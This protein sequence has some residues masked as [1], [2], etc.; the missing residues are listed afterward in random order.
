M[1]LVE[2]TKYLQKQ[3]DLLVTEEALPGDVPTV[4]AWHTG[5]TMPDPIETIEYITHFASKNPE[6]MTTLIRKLKGKEGGMEGL[7][8]QLLEHPESIN[9]LVK[10]LD[11]EKG[12]SHAGGIARAMAERFRTYMDDFHAVNESDE[13]SSML[14]PPV[15]YGD[16]DMPSDEEGGDEEEL[17]PNDEKNYDFDDD[18]DEDE[19]DTDKD[20]EHGEMPKHSDEEGDEEE[21][22]EMPKVKKPAKKFSH[23][24]LIEAM[25]SHAHMRDTMIK[26]CSGM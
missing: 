26:H 2:V 19:Y 11:G 9:E 20:S 14:S 23:D 6:L 5:K 3:N 13:T 7:M 21:L 10:H 22:P 1:S 4:T 16:E 15:G 12:S 25:G 18:S 17:D 24:N 8:E